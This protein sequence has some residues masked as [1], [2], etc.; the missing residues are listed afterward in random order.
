MR[1]FTKNSFLQ[2]TFRSRELSVSSMTKKYVHESKSKSH[3]TE[4]T[5]T[6]TAT[7]PSTSHFYG[8][9]FCSSYVFLLLLFSIRSMQKEQQNSNGHKIDRKLRRCI[10]SRKMKRRKK[11]RGTHKLG[12]AN[13]HSLSLCVSSYVNNIQNAVIGIDVTPTISFCFFSS[14]QRTALFSFHF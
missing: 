9:S 11:K 7:T 14:F 13:T 2:P 10:K 3:S 4:T 12:M 8:G 5:T 1:S 6:A